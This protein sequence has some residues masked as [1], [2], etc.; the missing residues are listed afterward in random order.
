MQAKGERNYHIFYA[1]CA[2]LTASEKLELQLGR[3]VDYT[4]LC[5]GL[6]GASLSATGGSSRSTSASGSRQATPTPTRV[7]GAPPNADPAN[8]LDEQ[9]NVEN[10]DDAVELANIRAAMRVLTFTD[11]EIW[12]ILRLLS[13]ILHV[14]NVTSTGARCTARLHLRVE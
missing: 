6:Y 11:A 4:Y 1:M 12:H 13:A 8:G 3:A 14:G 5:G 9:L 2:G 7:A 10:R